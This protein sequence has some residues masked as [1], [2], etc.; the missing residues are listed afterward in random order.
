MRSNPP[1]TLQTLINPDPKQMEQ[2][3]EQFLCKVFS[4]RPDFILVWETEPVCFLECV[5][6]WSLAWY[7][8]NHN[9]Q[10]QNLHS[11]SKA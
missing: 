6:V 9:V 5:L 11:D 8:A 7:Q 3:Q 2:F 1:T 4:L 10:N